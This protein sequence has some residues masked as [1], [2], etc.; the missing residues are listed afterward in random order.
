LVI[1]LQAGFYTIQTSRGAVTCQL[2]GRLKKNRAE[3]DIVAVGDRVEIILQ[4][5]GSGSIETVLPRIR[6]LERLAPGLRGEYQQVLLANPD[7]MVLVFACANPAPH[8]RMLD[9]FLV[10]CE[11][12]SIPVLIVANKVDLLPDQQT[13]ALFEFYPPLGYPVL[14]TSAAQNIGIEDLRELLHGKL[15]GFAGP[16]GVGKT[17]LLN[18]L[19]PG[20]GLGVKQVSQATSKGRHS[21]VVRELHALDGGGYVADLPGLRSLMLWDIEPEELDGYFPEIRSLVAH[22][23]FNDCTHRDEPG[24]AVRA[25][26]L[27]GRIA[28][29]RY[30]SYLRIRYG[31]ER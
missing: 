9:R 14:F 13:H 3:G 29:Q 12:Q 18:A 8:L 26:V 15:S 7:Q 10:I 19:Q 20:L 17:S 1:R 5:D 30:E 22:C 16:S 23:Q 4:D 28:P 21:T 25:A 2:R 24:C 31:E 11:K 6:A 27:E